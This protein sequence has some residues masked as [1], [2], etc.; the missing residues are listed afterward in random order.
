[1][2]DIELLITTLALASHLTVSV[3]CSHY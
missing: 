1:L 2:T 3:L